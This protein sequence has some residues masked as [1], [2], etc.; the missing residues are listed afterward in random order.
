M[1]MKANDDIPADEML[2]AIAI[3]AAR[4]RGLTA[5]RGA[6]FR[7]SAG[8]LAW[9]GDAVACCASGALVLACVGSPPGVAHGN[10]WDGRTSRPGEHVNPGFDMGMCFQDAMRE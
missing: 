7:D 3:A 1:T 5:T 2:L 4:S 8:R 6:A 9:E 10:D